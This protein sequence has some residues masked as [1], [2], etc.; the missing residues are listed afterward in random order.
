MVGWGGGGTTL[1]ELWDWEGVDVII[2][3][4]C[5]MCVSDNCDRLVVCV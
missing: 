3:V 1:R 5:E 2:G 4:D